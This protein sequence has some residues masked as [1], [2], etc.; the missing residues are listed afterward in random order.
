MESEVTD[1]PQPDSPTIPTVLPRNIKADT[2]NRL[3]R[4]YIGIEIGMKIIDFEDIVFIVHL[5]RIFFGRNILAVI[6]LFKS[7]DNLAVPAGNF[8]GFFRSKVVYVFNRSF[9]FN[10]FASVILY[11]H[12]VFIWHD[13]LTSFVVFVFFQWS[14]LHLRVECI[15]Q[16]VADEVEAKHR[17]KDQKTCGNPGKGVVCQNIAVV[18]GV[19]DISP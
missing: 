15:A 16:T 8:T 1:F 17:D 19:Y 5:G 12:F 7:A 13:I 9:G 14:S 2:V 6:F 18:Y 4:S 11:I 3:N 10:F